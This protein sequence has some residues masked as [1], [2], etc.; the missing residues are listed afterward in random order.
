MKVYQEITPVTGSDLFVILDSV[1]KGFEYPIHNHAEFEL[2]FV[3]GS[4]GTRIVGDSTQTYHEE[5]LVLIGP[6][7]FHKWDDEIQQ[8]TPSNPCRVMTIQFDMHLFDK[9]FLTKKPFAQIQALLINSGRGIRFKGQTRKQARTRIQQLTKLGGIESATEFLLLL[10]LLSKSHEYEFLASEG[11]NVNAVQINSKRLHAAYQYIRKHFHESGLKMSDVA[12]ELN[13]GDSA[14]SHFFKKATNRSFSDYLIAM[15]IEHACKLLIESD[16]QISR[17]AFLSG[18]NNMA[19]FNR[20]FKQAHDCSPMQF[21]KVY[22]EKSKFDWNKQITPGQFIPPGAHN[23]S[24][25]KPSSY[26]T[27]I[28]R[29]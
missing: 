2:T 15:R 4:A 24:V 6:Y 9:A 18:F 8:G 20:S 27:R 11:F 17:I 28:V 25:D 23:I 10:D 29:S 26:R 13:L 7:L 19:N 3:R 22:Q 21:R 1:N 16:E 12:G 14:F 5:D